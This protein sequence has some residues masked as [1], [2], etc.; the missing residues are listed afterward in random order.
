MNLEKDLVFGDRVL[1][2][3]IIDDKS[4]KFVGRFLKLA[5]KFEKE[6]HGLMD[7][8]GMF[9]IEGKRVS[10]NLVIMDF[11]TRA[12]FEEFKG[13]K[14]VTNYELIDTFVHELIHNRYKSEATTKRKAREFMKR[15][16]KKL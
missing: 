16:E 2:V 7:D 13:E 12:F 5:K 3:N 10:E 9:H 6:I 4:K 11:F 8:Y 14:Y 15:I 1:S